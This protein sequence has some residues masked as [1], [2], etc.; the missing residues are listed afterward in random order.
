MRTTCRTPPQEQGRTAV[1][2]GEI[3]CS[4]RAPRLWHSVSARAG[5][6][7]PLLKSHIPPPVGRMPVPSYNGIAPLKFRSG[8]E[9]ST[10]RPSR[11][12]PAMR[13]PRLT[14]AAAHRWRLR[15]RIWTGPGRGRHSGRSGHP[16]T[17][18]PGPAPRSVV[19]RGDVPPGVRA[20]GRGGGSQ[21]QSPLEDRP[22]GP[23]CRTAR[24]RTV[25]RRSSPRS[26]Q[27]RV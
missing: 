5:I 1:R 6:G 26:R 4:V 22:T 15:T 25:A 17:P 16:S 12:G 21:T 23:A 14:A 19:G 7:V 24:R 3:R 11:A 9:R 13:P 2:P 20:V 10:G 8:R 27:R 18:L